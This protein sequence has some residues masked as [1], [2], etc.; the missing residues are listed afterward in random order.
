[1][2]DPVDRDAILARRALFLTT[3]LAAVHCA[4][5]HD[6]GVAPSASATATGSPTA[7]AT[8][9]ATSARDAP[10]KLPPF[11][12][13]VSGAPP[14]GV[15]A[16]IKEA[17]KQR[18][19]YLE[20]DVKRD[21]EALR[22]VWERAPSCD[23]AAPDCRP[24]WRELGAF[25]KAL[26]EQTRAPFFGGC[27]AT[28]GETASL[29]A[30]RA[31]HNRY[32]TELIARVEQHL[33]AVAAS[34]SPQGEQEWLRLMANAK[35]PPPMPCLSPCAMPDVSAVLAHVPFARDQSALRK[36]DP[37]MKAALEQALGV[38]KAQRKPAKLI[39][40]G[41]A[42]AGEKDAVELAKARAKG[43][44]E[45][46]ISQGLAKDRVE[47]V[48]LGVDYPIERTDRGDDRPENRRVDFDVAP[49]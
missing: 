25:A 14:L 47:W 9:S 5:P 2:P 22:L 13:V 4:A 10:P 1:M 46:L 33:T 21:L 38:H 28:A 49:L 31:A 8:P 32:V 43:V 48:G 20:A 12:E 29:T 39:V 26:Y 37:T 23:A 42:D 3:A 6:G 30:R 15:P 19:V 11:A 16:G 34:F 18:L 36:D 40:R 17:E 45:H 24:E 27:G 44:A 35:K 7:T 41:H